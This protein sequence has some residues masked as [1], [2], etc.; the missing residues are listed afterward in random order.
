MTAGTVLAVIGFFMY[1]QL[2]LKRAAHDASLPAR[3][4]EEMP[5]NKKG[6]DLESTLVEIQ[7]K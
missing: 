3:G 7:A 2:K 1:S 5:L 6:S 4:E